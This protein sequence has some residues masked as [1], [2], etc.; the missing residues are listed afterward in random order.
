V[1][2]IKTLFCNLS[3][4]YYFKEERIRKKRGLLSPSSQPS[5]LRWRRS[6]EPKPYF[7]GRIVT[8]ILM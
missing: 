8:K 7:I 1:R 5:P 6:Q 4:F 3:F 2:G